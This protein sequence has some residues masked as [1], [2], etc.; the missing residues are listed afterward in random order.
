MRNFALVAVAATRRANTKEHQPRWGDDPL[1]EFA[2]G[3][4]EWPDCLIIPTLPGNYPIAD[5]PAACCRTDAR[6]WSCWADCEETSDADFQRMRLNYESL[7]F[8]GTYSYHD[9]GPVMSIAEV[10]DC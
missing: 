6:M 7:G 2:V 9:Y 5:H 8:E 3:Q 1:F 10:P 4:T